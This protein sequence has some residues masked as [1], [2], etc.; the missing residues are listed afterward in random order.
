[1]ASSESLG[2]PV[3]AATSQL[4]KPYGWATPLPPYNQTNPSSFD[5]SGLIAWAYHQAGYHGLDGQHYTGTEVAILK[6]I[7]VANAQPGD[8][9]FY[10]HG[11][12]VPYHVGMVTTSG[13]LIEAPDY[14]IPVR[15]RSYTVNDQD[16]MAHAG[17]WPGNANG[18]F[19]GVTSG[20]PGGGLPDP[21]TLTVPLTVAQRAQLKAYLLAHADNPSAV[22][23][24]E[25]MTDAQLITL[26]T[27]TLKVFGAG[28]SA[29]G[30]VTGGI[31]STLDALNKLFSAQLWIRVGEFA[32]GFVLLAVAANAIVKGK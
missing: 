32:V 3:A 8:C 11:G 7:P 13:Q 4:G 23:Q 22:G 31:T 24:I 15:V 6:T 18:G 27:N 28:D 25:K 16:V 20:S 17:Q 30:V 2:N 26:Y 14:G 10:A 5:C 9:I 21:S 29:G 1:M 12:L 19:Q